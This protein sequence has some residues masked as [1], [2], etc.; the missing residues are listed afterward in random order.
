M[1]F[2]TFSSSN[3]TNTTPKPKISG[4]CTGRGQNIIVSYRRP[5]LNIC[6]EN[7]SSIYDEKNSCTQEISTVWLLTRTSV[8]SKNSIPNMHGKILAGLCLEDIQINGCQEEKK[9]SAAK[10]LDDEYFWRGQ[11]KTHMNNTKLS[12]ETISK[13]HTHT[14][15]RYIGRK[16]GHDFEKD[17]KRHTMNRRH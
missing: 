8:N 15:T 10:P 17:Q 12:H 3:T 2:D 13:T 4:H 7:M 5:E 11:F 9:F 1:D 6:W 14:H 16:R